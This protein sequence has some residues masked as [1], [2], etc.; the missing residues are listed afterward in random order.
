MCKQIHMCVQLDT[1]S[2][3][4]LVTVKSVLIKRPVSKIDKNDLN[5]KL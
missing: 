4:F 1:A 2:I 3:G 5:D